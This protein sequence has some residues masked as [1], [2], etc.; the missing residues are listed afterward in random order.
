MLGAV[1]GDPVGDLGLIYY[2]GICLK[3]VLK[4]I[5]MLTRIVN[6]HAENR[7]EHFPNTSQKHRAIA[8]GSESSTRDSTSDTANI[9][10]AWCNDGLG[11]RREGHICQLHV[12]A[13]P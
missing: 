7:T 2:P 8:F 6:I 13:R 10:A 1:Y 5:R 12:R 9:L 11:L 3:V 4:K